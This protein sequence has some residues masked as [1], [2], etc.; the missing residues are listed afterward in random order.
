MLAYFNKRNYSDSRGVPLMFNGLSKIPAV[1][2]ADPWCL[3][4]AERLRMLWARERRVAYYYEEANNSTFRYRAYNMVQALNSYDHN[5]SASYFF[6]S[7]LHRIDDIADAAEILVICRSGYDNHVNQLITAFH[8]RRKRVLFD[9]EDLVFNTD[10]ASLIINALD[11]DLYKPEVWDYWFAYLSRMGTTLKLC[12][13]ALTTNEFLA[14]RIKEFSGL[15]VA[16]IP[17]F[18]NREQLELSDRLFEAKS[19]ENPGEDGLIHFGYFSGSPSHNKD[20]ALIIPALEALFE[21]RKDVGLVLVGYIEAGP[22]LEHF[23]ARVKRYPFHDF[24]N[25]QRLIASVE[26]NLMPLQNNVFANCKS[27]L[28]YFEAAIVGTPSI[29]SPSFTYAKVI[30]DGETGYIARSCSWDS[31]LHCALDHLDGYRTMAELACRDAREKYAW[32]NQSDRI[33]TALGNLTG[34]LKQTE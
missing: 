10:F 24:V 13:G 31:V 27:E 16:I 33:V 18:I 19:H 15:P 23:G 30:N 4:L 7:D 29:A 32:F 3:G 6:K 25:L 2:Y 12:D 8:N 26:F 28:K 1:P 34:L 5:V 22:I 17:N 14:E 11:Q 9:I 20:F 21:A